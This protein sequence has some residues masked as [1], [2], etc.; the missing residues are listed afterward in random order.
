MS[1]LYEVLGVNKNASDKEIKKA[2]R[3]LAVKYH[4]D[5]NPS[6][7]EEAEEKFKKLSEAYTVLTDPQKRKVYDRY[8]E[9]G[10]KNMEQGNGG[11]SRGGGFSFS[12]SSSS[13]P[14]D[15]AIKI[16]LDLS[17]EKMANG[18]HFKITLN[19]QERCPQCVT[20]DCNN[21]GGKGVATMKIQLGPF[22]MLKKGT[23]AGC[24]GLGF[25]SAGNCST[26]SRSG[27]VIKERQIDV[28]VQSGTL[29]E[30]G[31]I[32]MAGEGHLDGDLY[33]IVRDKTHPVY[34]RHHNSLAT[35]RNISIQEAICGFQ[36][37]LKNLYGGEERLKVTEPVKEGD[38]RT[39][40]G[41]GL[42]DSRNGT[43]DLQVKFHITY[44]AK[45]YKIS[46]NER[47]LLHRILGGESYKK[48]DKE[49]IAPQE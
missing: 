45:V 33:I 6:A 4:P 23:C 16:P 2:Y 49:S 18:G 7:E 26:C 46:D 20:V 47:E 15:N 40:K 25:R 9:E 17:L 10:L 31:A 3:K 12:F 41:L 22:P 32:K 21:C 42:P 28:K 37:T 35:T 29:P 36:F 43:G 19:R 5:K 30:H 11:G 13:A 14:R 39:F 38:V 24:S 44:P 34:S 48:P 8:G 1:N 27:K